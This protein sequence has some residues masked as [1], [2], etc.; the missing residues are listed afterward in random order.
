MILYSQEIG[1]RKVLGASLEQLI[2]LQLK[3]FLL[4]IGMAILI[5]SPLAWWVMNRWL[6]AFAFRIDIPWWIFL[7][8]GLAA[9]FIATLTVSFQSIKTELANPV[10]ALRNE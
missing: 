3:G 8:A 2:S 9:I 5:A 10:K 1:I 6:E 4:L 7:L